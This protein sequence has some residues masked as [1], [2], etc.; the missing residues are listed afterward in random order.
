[1]YN[2]IEVNLVYEGI[3]CYI[4]IDKIIAFKPELEMEK[5]NHCWIITDKT[6]FFCEENLEEIKNKIYEATL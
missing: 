6:V 1:M 3:K 5:G 4:N 2:F